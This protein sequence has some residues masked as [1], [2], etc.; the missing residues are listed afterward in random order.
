[1]VVLAIM[2]LLGMSLVGVSAATYI[3]DDGFKFTRDGDYITIHEYVGTEENVTIPSTLVNK[4]VTAINEY[5][6]MYNDVIKSITIPNTVTSIGRG[7]FYGCQNLES[8]TLPKNC[9]S[10]GQYMFYNCAS[11]KSVTLPSMLKE[12]PRYC[13]SHCDSIET[14]TLPSTA[15][16]IGDYAFSDCPNL[17]SVYVSKYTTSISDTAFEDAPQAVI[18]GYM[19]TYAYQYA[20]EKSIPF[21][22]VDA[23]SQTLYVTFYDYDGSIYLKV[24]VVK[25]GSIS[26]PTVTPEKPGTATHYYDFS[27]WEGNV[28]NIQQNEFVYPVYTEREKESDV[29]EV[30]NKYSVVFLDGNDVFIEVQ[31]VEEGNNAVEPEIIPTKASTVSHYYEFEGWDKSFKNVKENLIVKPIFK[32]FPVEYTVKFMSS[33]DEVLSQQTVYYGDSATA[34]EAPEY[35]GYTF[36]GWDKKFGFVSS[37]LKVYPIYEKIETPKEPLPAKTTGKLRIELAGGN[38]FMIAVNDGPL[39]PQGSS[40]VNTKMPVGANV[41][42]VANISTG[43]EFMGWMNEYGTIISDTDTYTFAASGND[44]FKAVYKTEVE[45]VNTVIFMNSKAASGNGQILDMQYYAAGDSIEFPDAPAQVGYE[46]TGWNMT[47][48]DIQASLS[49]GEDV[50]VVANW[51]RAKVYITAQVEGGKIL[52]EAQPGGK[53]LAYGALTV[54]ADKAE[55]GMK[56]AYWTD[57]SGAV[58]SYDEEYKSY[59]ATNVQLVAVFVPEETEIVKSPLVFMNAD[60]TI[61]DEK[62]QYTMSW[63]VD[64]SIGKVTAAGLIIT[65]KEDYKAETFLHGSGDSKLFDRTVGSSQVK[66]KNTT[67]VTKGDSFYEHTYCAAIFVVYTDA[68]TGQSVTIYSDM[69]EVT[70]PAP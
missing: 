54:V 27:Y 12:I 18:H 19:N 49:K 47:Y 32:E 44:Y 8:V 11:L 5:A 61:A 41:T 62:I 25:G 38:S 70:K 24:P 48:D 60:P 57:E 34:P 36:K 53:Y 67:S 40:Y 52:T 17:R 58:L 59:P 13:F 10:V 35:E 55:E 26:F 20:I 33:G 9:T 66:Q 46:F 39:R 69:I 7:I 64:E 65:D 4:T 22:A 43:D 14:V 28:V 30:I 56:F 42:L 29:P 31:M 3:I 21:S 68:K 16:T 1:S 23:T 51:E 15:K 6:F 50:L 2:M 63:D 37:D 45:N